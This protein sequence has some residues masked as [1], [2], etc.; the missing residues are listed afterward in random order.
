[1]SIIGGMK[2]PFP[3]RPP[4]SPLAPCP[5]AGIATVVIPASLGTSADGQPYA[6][7]NGLYF[8]TLVTYESDKAVYL[9]GN[10]GVPVKVNVQEDIE[11]PVVSVNDKTGA[12]VLVISDLENDLNY[13]TLSEVNSAIAS[14][15]SDEA[16]ARSAADSGL[17]SQIDALAAASDV[18]DI[19]G[20]YAALQAYD[21]SRLSDNDIIKVLQDETHDDETTY[22]RWHASTQT[23]SLIGEE[24]PYY[25]KAA[26]DAQFVPQTRTVNSKPLSSDIALTASDVSA[27]PASAIVQTTGTSTTNVMSQDATTTAITNA[28]S[29]KQ[30]TLTAGSNITIDP[31]TNVISATDTIYSDFVGTDGT[32]AGTAGL[33]PAPGTTDAGSFL[34]A[35]GTWSAVPAPVYYTTIGTNTDGAMT[36]AATTS[37]VYQGGTTNRVAIGGATTYSDNSRVMIAIGSGAQVTYSGSISIGKSATTRD[38]GAVGIGEGAFGG[39]AGVAIGQYAQTAS[40][41]ISIGR[42]ANGPPSSYPAQGAVALGHGSRASGSYD[43]AIGYDTVISSSSSIYGVAVGSGAR[44]DTALSGAVALGAF[45]KPTRSGEVHIGTTN[46]TYG[47]NGTNY[48]VFGGVHDGIDVHDAATVGQLTNERPLTGSAA[49]TTATVGNYIGQLYYDTTNGDLYYCSAITAQG[50]TPETYT[51]TWT[52]VGG[53]GS[54]ATINSTDWSSLWQ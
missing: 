7:R 48:R 5:S 1:M 20:T 6:P 31:T 54:V 36:Q 26:A 16:D 37:M 45:S 35:D 19:V 10:A 52:A 33:V 34:K 21:T 49:P 13:Q 47:Y 32:A 17:Q 3:P 2:K 4:L 53:G 11:F 30:D 12:V 39:T 27:V 25:T 46:T 51:Y 23:F 18:T 43:I 29:T 15:V 42:Y 44:F 38:T 8:N 40:Y 28:V 14:A 9:Y 50:T 41:G 22:Y 24:G